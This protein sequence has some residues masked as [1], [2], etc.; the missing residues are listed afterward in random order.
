MAKLE[1]SWGLVWDG[2]SAKT[3][4]GV[5]GEYLRYN[6]PHKMSMYL[7]SGLPLI[8]WN[9]SA[10]ASY[11]DEKGIGIAINSIDQIPD[12]IKNV[13]VEQYS[14]FI[15]NVQKVGYELRKGLHLKNAII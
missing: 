15:H 12:A 13:S 5:Y 1:G 14:G 9:E 4:S 8:V 10:L 7:A 3:C 11:V 6:S 2:N